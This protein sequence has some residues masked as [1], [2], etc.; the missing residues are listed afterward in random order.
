[1]VPV[2][3]SRGN[4]LHE[5]HQYYTFNCY[6]TWN[7]F[8]PTIRLWKGLSQNIW[9]N[10]W[11]DYLV[12]LPDYV[13]CWNSIY[14]VCIFINTYT[15]ALHIHLYITKR[16]KHFM[17]IISDMWISFITIHLLTVRMTN[18]VGLVLLRSTCS[19]NVTCLLSNF[20]LDVIQQLK[21]VGLD[22][23]AQFN[24]FINISRRISILYMHSWAYAPIFRQHNMSWF[25]FII[26]TSSERENLILKHLWY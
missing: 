21:T 23:S 2:C 9:F 5:T 20:I 8:T 24:L 10:V 17:S 16:W 25:C 19:M 3:I 11:G 7:E 1:M 18:D 4:S 22:M 15:S 12:L 26:I 6:Q 14:I 13:I